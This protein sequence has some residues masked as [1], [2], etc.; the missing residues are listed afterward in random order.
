MQT[1]SGISGHSRG[2]HEHGGSVDASP[3]ELRINWCYFAP[4][5]QQREFD[6]KLAAHEYGGAS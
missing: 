3:S 6:G 2:L 1:V 4:A 5:E